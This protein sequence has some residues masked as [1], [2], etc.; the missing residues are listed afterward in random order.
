MPFVI[1]HT[2][3]AKGC[4]TGCNHLEDSVMLLQVRCRVHTDIIPATAGPD[5]QGLV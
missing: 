4:T 2:R 5:Q 3:L 1:Q